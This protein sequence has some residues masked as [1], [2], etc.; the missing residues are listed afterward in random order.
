[1]PSRI[2]RSKLGLGAADRQVDLNAA[3][4][5]EV[6]HRPRQ[7]SGDRAQWHGPHLDDRIL[8]RIEQHLA[9]VQR[10][11][12]AII[13]GVDACPVVQEMLEPSA[14]QHGFT[15]GVEQAV[16]L[17]RRGTDRPAVE[18]SDCGAAVATLLAGVVRDRLGDSRWSAL[19]GWHEVHVRQ[20][21]Q[22]ESATS[23]SPGDRAAQRVRRPQE[24][25]R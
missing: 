23:V 18:R 6:A 9:A 2:T 1:M 10:L 11:F 3:A 25:M 13:A 8:K 4:R 12:D 14:L 24:R 17:G 21:P 7:R 20:L 15:D 19:S 16:D 22:A 5:R